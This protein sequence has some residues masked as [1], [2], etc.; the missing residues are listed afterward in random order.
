MTLVGHVDYALSAGLPP[1]GLVLLHSLVL[2]KR[3]GVVS[4]EV[5]FAVGY[6]QLLLVVVSII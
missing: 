1:L 5:L 4:C 6:E 3:V 2:C